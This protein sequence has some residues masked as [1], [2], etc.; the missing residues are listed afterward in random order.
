MYDNDV[1]AAIA[2][3]LS[4]S[5]IGIIR[6][7]G[8][9]S[10]EI[11]EHV[12][13][14]KPPY[15]HRRIYYGHIVDNNS[16]ILD[17]VLVSIFHRPN[18]YTGEDSF[19]INCHG[20][21]VALNSI[22][23]LLISNGARIANPGEFTKRAFLNGKLDLSQAEAVEKII[24]SKSKR[25]LMIAQRQLMGK[26]SSKIE[27]IREKIL[28]LMAENEV[29]IDHPEEELSQYSIND[30]LSIIKDVELN[31]KKIL[32]S[33]KYGNAIF[34][35]VV[36]AL[37]GKPN[38]GKSSL[39]NILTHQERSIVTDIPGT[40][41][42]IISEQF[43]IN[44]IP[45]TVQDTA[46]IRKSDDLVESMGVERSLKAIDN[47][48]IV[49]CILDA[50]RNLDSDDFEIL[51]YIK[52]LNKEAVLVINKIDENIL[53]DKNSLNFEPSVEI[54]CKNEIGLDKLENLISGLAIGEFDDSDIVSLNANQKTSIQNA[55]DMCGNIAKD[56]KM[57]IDPSL[58]AV[59]LMAL[60]DYLDEVIGKISNEDML[61]VMFKNFCIGK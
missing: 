58:I 2:T 25:A 3:G 52:K 44:G 56:I 12:F 51:N 60:T 8:R 40:T 21:I 53:F 46:G 32:K 55:I 59:D 18:S 42:D 34:E 20:G 24:A 54:S 13:T 45:F 48:D 23:E 16:D 1:I 39:L 49:L 38:V 4:A 26:F 9:G 7:S 6:V 10:F 31:L 19:E 37:V 57:D 61:D 36:I 41:R 47:A 27:K 33:A 28:L 17:E 35:G 11:L 29:I 15:D 5:A 50:S 43:T 30:K 22:L 14:K